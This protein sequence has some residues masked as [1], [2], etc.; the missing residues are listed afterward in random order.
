MLIRT[1]TDLGALV[2]DRRRRLGWS[3]AHLA[4]HVG[5]GRLWVAQMERGKP[6]AQVDLVLRAL[7]AL[8]VTLGVVPVL[9]AAGSTDD[10]EEV[11]LDRL[12]ADPGLSSG[13]GADD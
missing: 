12:L 3:Q 5:V 6:G 1:A 10:I 4:D 2:R 11:D 9:P 7:Q 13:G 8:G